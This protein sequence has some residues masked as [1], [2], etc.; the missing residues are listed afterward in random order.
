MI[1]K[2]DIRQVEFNIHLAAAAA[3]ATA[4]QCAIVAAAV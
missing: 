4:A 2:S 1:R 3:T